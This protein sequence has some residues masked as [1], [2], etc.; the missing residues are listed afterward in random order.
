[1]SDSFKTLIRYE[2]AAFIRNRMQV[3]LMLCIFLLGI[4]AICYG[5]FEM[6]NQSQTIERLLVSERSEFEGY[7][8]SF[9]GDA[10]VVDAKQQLD[11][12]SKPTF[13]WFR[14]GYHA[15]LPPHEFATLSLGQ[16][17]LYRYYYRLTG[18]SLYYQLFENEI[19]NPY[20]LRLGNLDLSF[21]II[22][23]F[24][25]LIIAF[26]YSLYSVEKENEI[27]PLLL[28]Q[29]VS[30]TKILLI[31]L[32]F[33]F[34][35]IAGL[36]I[37]LSIIGFVIS[38]VSMNPESLYSALTWSIG[39]IVY[40]AFWFGLLFFLIGFRRNTAF[41]AIGSAGLWVL[42]LIVIPAILNISVDT[43]Y[44]LDSMELAGLTRRTG[45]E[46]EDD[47]SESREV[48][49]EFLE[50]RPQYSNAGSFTSEN[51]GAKAYAAFT[52]LKDINSQKVV[53]IYNA[54]IEEREEWTSRFNWLN[55]A[56]T[57]QETFSQ[58]VKSDISNYLDFQTEIK[59]FHNDIT[60][61]YFQRLFKDKLLIQSDYNER[62]RFGLDI[63]SVHWKGVFLNMGTIV[64]LGALFFLLGLV[65]LNQK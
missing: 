20:Y 14:H 36:G 39:V 15:V 34:L 62:P 7:I 8:K 16:R 9:D 42:F 47:E 50:H 37:V 64:L 13:A 33:Y 24:P 31:R 3:A 58:I 45:L 12:A 63:G 40:C 27:L 10:K 53:D 4:F 6:D 22:Y 61:F 48:I 11:I 23:I 29:A 56:V 30:I 43:K 32:F 41:N 18:M 60:D 46:N 44:P 25:L 26:C 5:K 21:L 51:M 54:A 1:M 52:V 17:D 49:Q 55:P 57:M 28:I 59:K 38:G 35:I 19:A 2:W 65:N